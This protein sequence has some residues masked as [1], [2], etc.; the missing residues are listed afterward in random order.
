MHE[1]A[2][3]QTSL[4]R[5]LTLRH[6][7]GVLECLA[8]RSDRPLFAFAIDGIAYDLAA[9][10]WT[11]ASVNC[12]RA[13]IP[14]SSAGCWLSSITGLSPVEH[15]A[16]GA[17]Q[18]FG[19]ADVTA[20]PVFAHKD[21]LF[22]CDSTVFEGMRELGR[23]AICCDSD[24]SGLDSA[25]R[26]ALCRGAEHFATGS[27]YNCEASPKAR[28]MLD[29]ISDAMLAWLKEGPDIFVWIFIDMDLYIHHHGY[30]GHVQHMLG[31]L[32]SLFARFAPFADIVAYSDHGLVPTKHDP[33]I[34]SLLEDYCHSHRLEMAGAGRMRWL[35]DVNPKQRRDLM[36]ELD[37]MLPNGISIHSREEIFPEFR[38]HPSFSHRVGEILLIARTENF[39]TSPDY[40]YDHGGLSDTELFVPI[41]FWQDR[42]T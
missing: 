42:R 19:A 18:R 34:A 20:M 23:R 40:R 39:L 32:D 17:V 36:S 13:E 1:L 33:A 6:T 14:T 8:R 9:R 28:A 5:P 22:G 25:W 16:L 15:G 4:T 31:A 30:D 41:A 12:M 27:F 10:Y 11:S 21:A 2:S 3:S 26:D 37:I 38:H 35:Y 7:R 29:R 24:L